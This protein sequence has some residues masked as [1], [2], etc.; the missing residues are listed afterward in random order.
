MKQ[1]AQG[2]GSPL[3]LEKTEETFMGQSSKGLECQCKELEIGH[4]QW[5]TL[6]GLK[7]E[8]CQIYILTRFT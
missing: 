7:V 2:R 6:T 3:L 4:E 5:G 8:I 1:Q